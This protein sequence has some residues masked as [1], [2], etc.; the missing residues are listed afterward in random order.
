MMKNKVFLKLA[1]H[2][3]L[4]YKALMRLSTDFLR[5]ACNI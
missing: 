2:T 3:T 1:K 4:N 5:I